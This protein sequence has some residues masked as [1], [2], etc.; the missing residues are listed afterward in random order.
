MSRGPE[1]WDYRKHSWKG[2]VL[3]WHR[4]IR[5]PGEERELARG[6]A[7]SGGLEAQADGEPSHCGALVLGV[8]VGWGL[9]SGLLGPCHFGLSQ[10]LVPALIPEVGGFGA[11]RVFIP[12]ISCSVGFKQFSVP[13]I[14]AKFPLAPGSLMGFLW[15]TC[16][17]F[18]VVLAPS[19]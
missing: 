6:L 8:W 9:T 10:T 17:L 2:Q 7:G 1:V 11:A 14:S 4:G 5:E 13:A 18:P 15:R 16:G 3:A 12:W 19:P